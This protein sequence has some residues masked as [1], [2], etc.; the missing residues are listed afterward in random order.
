VAAAGRCLGAVEGGGG[1]EVVDG[2][3][4]SVVVV[5]VE[6]VVGSAT[7]ARSR[8]S[9]DLVTSPHACVARAASTR[10]TNGQRTRLFIV[11]SEFA[12]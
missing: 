3:G 4:G 2:G 12:D 8:G 11:P 5:D 1:G 10:A 9:A 7:A 6:V